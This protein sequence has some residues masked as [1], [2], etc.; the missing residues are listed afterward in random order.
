MLMKPLPRITPLLAILAT[1]S[2]PLQAAVVWAFGD[3]GI[4]VVS[5][6][7]DGRDSSH[8]SQ[9][10]VIAPSLTISRNVTEGIFNVTEEARYVKFTS[11]AGTEWAFAG[12]GP[13]TSQNPTGVLFG[14]SQWMDL[15]FEPWSEALG[16]HGFLPDRTTG[17]LADNIV[18]T[19]G[20]LHVIAEDIYIDIVFTEW[21]GTAGTWSYDR[22]SPIPEPSLAA[23][24]ALAA[25]G[26]LRRKR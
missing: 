13:D 6:G 12:L 21:G 1:I 9:Q 22:A 8:P 18:G 23:L 14:A 3:P 4:T 17:N 10:D 2:N 15:T 26:L 19:S 24:L 20:V 16:R 11:P 5:A 25:A 7:G